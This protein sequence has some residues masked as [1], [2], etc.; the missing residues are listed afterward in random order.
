MANPKVPRE[1][2]PWFPTIN[3]DACI[4]DQECLN[5]CKNNVFRWDEAL[6]VPEV[7]NPY[8]CVLGCDACKQICPSEAISFP[9]HDELR[10][11]MRQLISESYREAEKPEPVEVNPAQH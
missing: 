5:F 4:H 1:K 2:I 8:N 9:S 7:V 3:Y 6:G 10:R 11:I